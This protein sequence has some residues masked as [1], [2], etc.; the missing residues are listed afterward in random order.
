MAWLTTEHPV[1][2]AA[3]RHAAGSGFDTHTW[4]LAWTLHSFLD[5]QG[6]WHD[7]TTAW[8][9]ALYAA[10]RLDDPA[11][12]A[13]AH[14]SIAR[15]HTLLNRHA[16]AHAHLQHALDLHTRASDRAGQAHA[17]HNL[18]IL[19]E[20]QGYLHE[21]LDHAQQA[22]TH[23]RSARHLRGQAD[24]LNAVGWY[25]AQLGDHNQ[26]LASCG[27]AL[28]LYQQF[29]DRHGEAFTWDSLGYA[30]H[31]LGHHTKAADCYQHATDLL[32]DLGDRFE[33]A[34]T[35]TNLGDNHHAAGNPTAARTAWTNALHILTDLDHPDLQDIRAKLHN[36]DQPFARPANPGTDPASPT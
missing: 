13:V 7:L 35:L 25:L 20:R 10:S 3:L 5:R 34:I 31:H 14:R 21:A 16:D 28:T 1:L 18:A 17:L 11:A 32:R 30:H 6:H 12:L 23:Y 2:L 8:R 15:A 26:A 19:W 4:Q 29:G 36:L 24:A 27:Q 9:A 22:L 33:E